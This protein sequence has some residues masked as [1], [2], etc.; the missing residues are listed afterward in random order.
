LLSPVLLVIIP[1]RNGGIC[2]C[3]A[4]P[5]PVLFLVIPAGNLPSSCLC[6]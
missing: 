5:L 4:L 3:F 2:L 6:L 1:Q